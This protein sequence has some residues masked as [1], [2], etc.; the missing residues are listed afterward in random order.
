MIDRNS[1]VVYL[2][3]QFANIIILV[4][5]A[6]TI[7]NNENWIVIIIGFAFSLFKTLF[8]SLL[9]EKLKKDMELINQLYTKFRN[10]IL[11]CIIGTF[12]SLLDFCLFT[13][14]ATY[15]GVYYLI[16]N[17]ISVLVGIT[18]SYLLNR[19]YNFKVKDHYK[20]RFAIFLAVGLCGL[21]LS[22]LILYIGV[23]KMKGEERIVKFASIVLV[24][25][26]QFLLNSFVTFKYNFD[27]NAIR[28]WRR[29]I[30]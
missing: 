23:D 13:V 15:F 26:G 30:L 25:G 6:H 5:F 21:L 3:H 4:M 10:L 17:C 24:V 28:S 19:A 2:L 1:S 12:T 20:K 11:Y 8:I 29:F 22:N 14:F 16:S 7:N 18:T 9:F 27:K